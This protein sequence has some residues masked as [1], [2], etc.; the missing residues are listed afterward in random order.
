MQVFMKR[1]I[2]NKRRRLRGEDV[3]NE[4]SKEWED[5]E[6]ERMEV[7]WK[8]EEMK[9]PEA[10]DEPRS[11]D[12]VLGY[13]LNDQNQEYEYDSDSD[14]LSQTSDLS[15]S[16][17]FSADADHDSHE[18]NGY[19]GLTRADVQWIDR[20]RVLAINPEIESPPQAFLSGRGRYNDYVSFISITAPQS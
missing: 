14:N 15:L 4:D 2:E 19:Y 11:Q 7:E 18:M 16:V 12:G 20:S 6:E 1:K 13:A 8:D 9:S 17:D 5:R 10:D 3:L